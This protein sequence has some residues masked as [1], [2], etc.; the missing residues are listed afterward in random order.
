M[1]SSKM[2]RPKVEIDI[3]E[4][5]ALCRMKP[6]QQDCASFFK[7]SLDTIER[8][9]KAHCG[10][11]FAEFRDQNMVHTRFSLIRSAIQKSATSDTMHIFC[12]KNLCKWN[13]KQEETPQEIKEDISSL[14][15]E[16]K[17]LK[18]L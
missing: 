16:F 11:T 15:E 3:D 6:T 13:D 2:G 5:A 9:I 10:L 1:A 17:A 4:L 12:L 14:V 7:C 18:K 8:V